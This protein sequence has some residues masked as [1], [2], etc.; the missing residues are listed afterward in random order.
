MTRKKR[1]YSAEFKRDTIDLWQNSD[2]SARQI[3]E[4]L[5]L[6]PGILYK[7]KQRLR[8]DGIE[9]FPGQGK[10][11]ASDE[12]VRRLERELAIV[13]QERD[14]LKKTVAIFSSPNKNGLR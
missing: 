9:A 2:R 8:E 11:K 1:V 4:E 12:H 6:T 7:W 14:I 5:G 13:K 3:E 10:L